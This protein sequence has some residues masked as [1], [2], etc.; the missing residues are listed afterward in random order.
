[1]AA[2]SVLST[3]DEMNA[4]AGAGVDAAGFT[5]ANKTAWGIQAEADLCMM[6]NFDLVTNVADLGV[7]FKAIVSEYVARYTAMSGILYNM[8]STFT[9]RIE[10]EDMVNVHIF[11]MKHI[12][13]IVNIKRVEESLTSLG[14]T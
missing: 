6:T 13:R 12:E 7:K 5:D 9:S 3:D 1:M 2:T 8:K 10:A 4:M 14:V 11:R